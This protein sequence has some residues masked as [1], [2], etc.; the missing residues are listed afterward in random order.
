MSIYDSIG[1]EP[2]VHRDRAMCRPGRLGSPPGGWVEITT[3]AASGLS[4]TV[5]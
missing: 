5:S 3:V 2:A 4:D 1:G